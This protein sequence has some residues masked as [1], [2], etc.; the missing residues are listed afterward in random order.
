MQAGYRV[1][2]ITDA[3]VYHV[4]ASARR[5]R[6]DIDRRDAPTSSTGATRC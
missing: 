3:V 4:E 2:V 5:R 1:R 6:R